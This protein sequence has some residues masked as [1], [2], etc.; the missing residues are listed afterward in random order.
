M[1]IPLKINSDNTV[2]RT[3]LATPGLFITG[4]EFMGNKQ[5]KF[6]IF[7]LFFFFALNNPYIFIKTNRFTSFM[8]K[9]VRFFWGGDFVVFGSDSSSKMHLLD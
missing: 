4:L 3:A 8:T 6:T 7:F 5:F 2:S 1:Y 9:S